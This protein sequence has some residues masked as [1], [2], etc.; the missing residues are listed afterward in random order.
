MTRL[1]KYLLA[2][3][4]LV[5]GL[6]TARAQEV[7]YSSPG[8]Y[9]WNPFETATPSAS[10]NS[11]NNYQP[12]GFSSVVS[13]NSLTP[14]DG[15][16]SLQSVNNN[17]TTPLNG[18]IYG[19]LITSGTN[20]TTT[21]YNWSFLYKYTG[22]TA[23]IVDYSTPVTQ[24]NAGWR[25]WIISNSTTPT[26][27]PT[28]LGMYFT[29]IGGNMRFFSKESLSYTRDLGLIFPMTA[30]HTYNVIFKRVNGGTTYVVYIDDIA[31]YASAQTNRLQTNPGSSGLATYTYSVLECNDARTTAN[32]NFQWDDFKIFRP[33]ETIAAVPYTP[34]S[35]A[36]APGATGVIVYEYSV[37]V[38]DVANIQDSYI[39][40]SSYPTTGY[41]SALNLYQ[42]PDN[43]FAHASLVSAYDITS[44]ANNPAV[45]NTVINLSSTSQAGTTYYY[46]VTA[47]I[48][49]TVSS[50]TFSLNTP[51]IAY[52]NNNG[53]VN[54]LSTSTSGPTFTVLSTD[55][56]TGISNSNWGNTGNWSTGV[57]P[58]ASNIARIGTNVAFTN[59][60]NFNV[61]GG[62]SVGQIQMGTLYAPNTASA[63]ATTLT[64]TTPLTVNSDITV[65]SKFPT[66]AS[67]TITLAG[68]S[69]LSVTGNLVFGNGIIP[70]AVQTASA[71]NLNYT[72]TGTMTIG[73]LITLTPITSGSNVFSPAFNQSAGI[74]NV[75]SIATVNPTSTTSAVKVTGGTLQL[76]STT[77][78]SALSAT[79]T[80]TI[81]FNNSGATVEYSGTN[82]TLYTS[83][84]ANVSGGALPYYNLI[85]SGSGTKTIG[86][87][88]SSTLTVAGAL[89][90]S[91]TTTDFSVYNPTVNVSGPWTNSGTATFG[92]G[93]VTVGGALTN[94]SGGALNLSNLST[95]SLTITGNY[96]NN[97]GGTFKTGNGTVIF[98]G[99]SQALIDNSTA[100]T[101]FKNVT[102]NGT[103]SPSISAGMGNFAV[104]STG[105]LT[106]GS[107]LTLTVGQTVAPFTPYFTLLSNSLGSANVATIPGT[108]SIRGYTNVQRY[109]TGQAT[110][111]RAYRL[112]SSPT[113]IS[114]SYTGSGN[115]NLSYI[116][117]PS[118]AGG[119]TYKG[120]YT[121]GPGAGFSTVLTNPTI[122]LYDESRPSNITSFYLGKDV[123]V[124]SIST[125]TISTVGT[126]SYASSPT[127][128]IPIGNGYFLYY[129]G[130][131]SAGAA[132]S[133]TPDSTSITA[134]G[135]INQQ[136]VSFN[137]WS[138]GTAILSYTSPNS[139]VTSK[140]FNL[141][142]N[143]YP[144]TI[145]LNKVIT[146][147]AAQ[148]Y[149]TFYQLSNINNSGTQTYSSW[150]GKTGMSS[151]GTPSQY[152]ASGQG[153]FILATA[154][155]QTLTFTE[156]AKAS[157]TQ[158]NATSLPPI[159]LSIP[160]K[161]FVNSISTNA[162]RSV[163]SLVLP[164][165]VLTG[166]HLMLKKDSVINESC[167]IYF[168]SDDS[169]KLDN[170]D[171]PVLNGL[172]PKVHMSSFTADGVNTAI[173]AMGDYT[174]GKRIKLY[175]KAVNDGLYK[176]NMTDIKNID[177]TMYNVYLVDN[178]KKDSLDMI[179]YKSYN[180]NIANAVAASFGANRFVLAVERKP[181]PLYLL[182]AFSGQKA[183]TGVQLSWK[184]NNEGNY[185]GFGLQK[186]NINGTYSLIDSVQS[187]SGG[188]Y[189]YID[190]N[191]VTG[192][193]IYRLEQNDI[194]GNV[195]Y[196]A[197]I[198]I[199]YNTTVTSGSIF[200]IY[201]NPAKELIT[202]SINSTTTTA[203]N[204]YTANIYNTAGALMG[205]RNVNTTTWVEDVTAYKPGTYI[206]ELKANTGDTVGK[207]K[208]VKTN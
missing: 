7:T 159:V 176:L 157:T 52:D 58:G 109:L 96:T 158:L 173:N 2:A 152:I 114:S 50:N 48:A 65:L 119:I 146:D 40:P 31:T 39:T 53:Y 190:P 83:N 5:F 81:S 56:W 26:L 184:T 35:S 6:N 126:S 102:F 100:G 3:L 68:T 115:L 80:N 130:T 59:Q 86:T 63:Y 165:H 106:V 168:T 13:S 15:S 174:K 122:Y 141:I 55:D 155:G 111:Y 51:N 61:G 154:S 20:V 24:N 101:V 195:T 97:S 4:P 149:T 133:S 16:Y 186:K 45:D 71:Y 171:G 90:T 60:P 132:S 33:T 72:S 137:L 18:G 29:Q 170:N 193:N 181:V 67:N 125:T 92:T 14:L 194:N 162:R 32:G 46:F 128:N 150:N 43:V 140:G 197:P 98:N 169:D 62:G 189:N 91:A 110:K 74:I 177:T 136:S 44:N 123:G 179:R 77:P 160:D 1:L 28:S 138:T 99:G 12:G 21:N 203:P 116:N 192:N 54:F 117:L 36:L 19:T 76:T 167:G 142:G 121:G 204:N 206:I 17:V 200:T 187:N 139:P 164:Q 64:V 49:S 127:V 42:G 87:A 198:I 103:G 30:G 135:Y 38:R 161:P 104:S 93:A 175:V 82:Q 112:L 70:S 22:S 124:K 9:Y 180:F 79:G 84:T 85:L 151:T 188:A 105:L 120:A 153:F 148:T 89:T 191:A 163:N 113:N 196:T 178:Y 202:F 66:S 25:Y 37:T 208:F 10:L 34:A 57:V 207:S 205:R 88:T 201:P 172:S 145:D 199:N 182:L 166:L 94:N 134:V 144:C 47:N 118:T 107:S 131:T 147:N 69:S 73:G 185:T 129:V 11:M 27:S 75:A 78:L 8:Y 108:S 95:N 23:N 41:F 156:N 143:P 183:T